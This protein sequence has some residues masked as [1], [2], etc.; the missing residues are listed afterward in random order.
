MCHYASK[1]SI[2]HVLSYDANVHQAIATDPSLRWDDRHD[3]EFHKFL[4][5]NTAPSCFYCNRYGHYAP[6]CPLKPAGSSIKTQPLSKE[7]MTHAQ[8]N[9]CPQSPVTPRLCS[10]YN[11]SG[12]CDAGCPAAAHRCN[13]SECS[14]NNPGFQC[15]L[16]R[17]TRNHVCP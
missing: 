8:G 16:L 6:S 7:P 1:Y 2:P 5:G 9:F 12:K 3:T 15:P 17:N 10:E 11:K 14:G 13:R 4:R